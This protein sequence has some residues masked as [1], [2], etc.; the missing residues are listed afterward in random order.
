MSKYYTMQNLPPSSDQSLFGKARSGR[1]DSN[2]E[3]LSELV[4][5]FDEKVLFYLDEKI[6]NHLFDSIIFKNSHLY[7]RT[8]LNDYSATTAPAYKAFEGFLF[9]L[10]KDLNLPSSG[11]PNFVATYF[12]EEKVDQTIDKL[13]NELEAKTDE[14]D[15]LSKE[16]KMQIKDTVKEMKR[17]LLHY[18]HTPAHF[19]G[20][21]IDTPEKA[22]QNILSIYRIINE[23][24]KTLLKVELVILNDQLH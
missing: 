20:E 6:I 15:K 19:H 7:L 9:Q 5:N 11:N 8:R 10:A 12:D 23:T 16:E 21:M 22:N 3:Q 2:R 1:H 4:S 24:V 13:V 14:M 17:F 18:R